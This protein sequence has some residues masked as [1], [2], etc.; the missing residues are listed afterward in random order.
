M[1]SKNNDRVITK[2]IV[3]VTIGIV[4]Y[5][6]MVSLP[7]TKSMEMS[8]TSIR[9]YQ[10]PGYSGSD[11]YEHNGILSTCFL[12]SP[13]NTATNLKKADV[14]GS[15]RINTI[16]SHDD[17]DDGNNMN[18][19][20]SWLQLGENIE[21][22]IVSRRAVAISS[23]ASIVAVGQPRRNRQQSQEGNGLVQVYRYNSYEDRWLQMGND[24]VSFFSSNEDNNDETFVPSFGSSISISDNGMVL[25]M[26]DGES[27]VELYHFAASS[28]KHD[29]ASS[30]S[31]SWQ[32]LGDSHVL[33]PPLAVT[34][35]AGAP[36]MSADGMVIAIGDCLFYDE[37]QDEER[38]RV[39]VFNYVPLSNSWHPMGSPLLGEDQDSHFGMS[40]SLSGDGTTL[41]VGA[42]GRSTFCKPDLYCDPDFEGKVGTVSVFQFR[43]VSAYLEDWDRVGQ[44]LMGEGDTDGFGKKVQLSSDAKVLAVGAPYHDDHHHNKH[45]NGRVR[46]FRWSMAN[47]NGD[48][49]TYTDDKEAWV[50]LGQP[51]DGETSHD[52]SGGAID[53]SDNGKVVVVGAYAANNVANDADD[54]GNARVFQYSEQNGKWTQVGDT[55]HGATEGEMSGY[56]VALSGDGTN[57]LTG[58]YAYQEGVRYSGLVRIYQWA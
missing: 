3:C 41:A 13:N 52:W 34:F 49:L 1:R 39:L 2:I 22:E 24:I 17:N 29:D 21:H 12:C 33:E 27:M 58:N 15:L 20:K 18:G 40:V 11:N 25:A 56:S 45:D 23:D 57:I 43:R 55:I 4:F 46:I 53:L 26:S 5:I 35:G 14:S 28:S 10:Y 32:P 30:S 8:D 36:T 31:G 38:G 7:K 54:T 19:A 47:N 42:P 6:T 51:I 48:A 37:D 50:P 16:S 44:V 9:D